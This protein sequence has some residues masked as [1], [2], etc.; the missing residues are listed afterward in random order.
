MGKRYTKEER[1]EALKLAEEIGSAAAARDQRRH[2]VRMA[3]SG[4]G[5]VR[6][7]G[8]RGRRAERGEV[9]S[10]EQGTPGATEPGPAGCGDSPG[11]VCFF[12]KHWRP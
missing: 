6:G 12:V 11:G 5:A 2:A 3:K 9:G 1:R 4:E 10:G 7:G 8:G